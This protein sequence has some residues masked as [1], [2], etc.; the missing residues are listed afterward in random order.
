MGAG[1]SVEVPGGGAEGYHVLRVQENSPGHKAGLE[2]FFDF[3]VMIGNTR[4]DQDDDRLKELLKTNVEKP[5]KMLIYSSKTLTTREVTLTPSSMWGGQGLLG[6]SIRFASFQGANEHVWH[7]LDV[8]PNSPAYIAGFRP[9]SDYIIGSDSLLSEEDDLFTLIAS[10]DGR[11]LKLFVYNSDADA[12]RE[13]II[14]PNN[15]WGGEGSIGCGIGYG[16][17]HRIPTLPF[18][19]GKNMSVQQQQVPPAPGDTVANNAATPPEAGYTDIPLQPTPEK[20]PEP[21]ATSTSVLPGNLNPATTIQPQFQV[22]VANLNADLLSSGDASSIPNV[23]DTAG[24]AI[25]GLTPM[26]NLN[27][28]QNLSSMTPLN[29]PPLTNLSTLNLPGDVTISPMNVPMPSVESLV[30]SLP[31]LSVVE[32][33]KTADPASEVTEANPEANVLSEPANN[34]E[35][36]K[37]VPAESAVIP[38]EEASETA[39]AD[40]QPTEEQSPSPANT[41]E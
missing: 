7:V 17:L 20:A 16:Y 30:A 1:Q 34:S 41:T 14:T 25:P 28:P 24:S 5:I 12:S 40:A 10:H 37:E 36:V 8:E 9:F 35:E 33:P 38:A 13:V 21:V 23:T 39:V 31:A 15:A 26:V 18:I 3:I 2:P 4:L 32:T 11:Q 6:V 19:E 27:I 29:I 22:P